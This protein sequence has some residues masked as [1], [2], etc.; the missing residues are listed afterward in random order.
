MAKHLDKIVILEE[1]DYV[2]IIKRIQYTEYKLE[3]AM[4]KIKLL[5]NEVFPVV[6]DNEGFEDASIPSRNFNELD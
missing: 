6:Y 1:T 2:D 5:E 4:N 3:V